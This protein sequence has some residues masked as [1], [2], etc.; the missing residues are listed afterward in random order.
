MR[1]FLETSLVIYNVPKEK[2]EEA[3][4][5]LSGTDFKDIA[6]HAIQDMLD[7]LKTN[8]LSQQ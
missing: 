5:F 1:L 6:E 4:Q 2:I 3:I 8:N 7:V